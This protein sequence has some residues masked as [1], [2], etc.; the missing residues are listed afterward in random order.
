MVAPKAVVVTVE[1]EENRGLTVN[2]KKKNVTA[3]KSKIQKS[4]KGPNQR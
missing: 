2:K 1:V 4:T 3:E